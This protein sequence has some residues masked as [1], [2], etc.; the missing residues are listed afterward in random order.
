LIR[1]FELKLQ[2]D[3]L[4][5]DWSVH[6]WIAAQVFP[7]ALLMSPFG[8]EAYLVYSLMMSGLYLSAAD[9]WKYFRPN[10]ADVSSLLIL[11]IA[12]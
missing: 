7:V 5:L 4:P 2:N 12:A 9:I 6:R 3:G 10:E 8:V 1:Q 11:R